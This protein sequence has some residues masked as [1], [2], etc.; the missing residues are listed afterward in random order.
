MIHVFMMIRQFLHTLSRTIFGVCY[1]KVAQTYAKLADHLVAPQGRMKMSPGYQFEGV[2]EFSQDSGIS[3]LFLM[4]SYKFQQ[5]FLCN[6]KFFM[7][8]SNQR[9][10][11]T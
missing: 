5:L 9:L 2:N 1:L 6:I 11:L 8:K 4:Y 7:F 10:S 3:N